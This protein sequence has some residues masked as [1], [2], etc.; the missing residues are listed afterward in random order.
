[1]NHNEQTRKINTGRNWNERT[2]KERADIQ[3]QASNWGVKNIIENKGN[4]S[5]T[6]KG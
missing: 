1:M 2:E 6:E 4:L 5:K 3:F